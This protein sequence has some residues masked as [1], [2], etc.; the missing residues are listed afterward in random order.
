MNLRLQRT[1]GMGRP[2]QREYYK[3]VECCG[4]SKVGREP[5]LPIGIVSAEVMVLYSLCAY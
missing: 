3:E 4:R 2:P 5:E 1:A